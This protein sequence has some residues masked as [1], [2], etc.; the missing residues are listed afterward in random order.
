MALMSPVDEKPLSPALFERL[1]HK[2]RE[3]RIANPGVSAVVHTFPNP[4]RPG[5]RL[6]HAQCWGEYYRVCCPFCNDID[7]KLWIN[8]LY[9][10]E[11]DTDFGRRSGTYLACCYKNNC[12]ATPGRS[13]QLENLI[14]GPGRPLAA[15]LPIREG[16]VDTTRMVVSVPGEIS[17]LTA[18]PEGH[19]AL[20]Y[21]RS[22]NFD[23]RE[24][25]TFFNVGFCVEP[26]RDHPSMRERIYI[27]VYH[28]RELVMFQGRRPTAGDQ[29]MKYYTAGKKSMALYN[30]DRAATQLFV[31][32]V[33]GVPSA[34]RL[35]PFGVA[36]FGKT[37]SA[38]QQTVLTQTWAGKP[39][40]VMLDSDAATET[41]KMLLQLGNSGLQLV[42]VRLPDARDPADYSR[43]ELRHLLTAAADDARVVVDLSRFGSDVL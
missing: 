12:L 9:G 13:Q 34:W 28:E 22:R 5:T 23:P 10:A 29:P 7:F 6:R 30:Y 32:I 40:F 8:H 24:L 17:P 37:L 18:L 39:A 25:E 11:Y 26:S 1:K 41:E 31:V 38:W 20:Q 15:K 16:R 2:F 35:N 4:A 21:L 3:V 36:I 33:E 19:A 14:F 43:D 42:P 27:P